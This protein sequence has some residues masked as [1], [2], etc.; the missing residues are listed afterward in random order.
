M[1]VDNSRK[2][3]GTN[4]RMHLCFDGSR[5]KGTCPSSAFQSLKLFVV[6]FILNFILFSK[7]T[8]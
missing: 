1:H 3:T 5:V 7:H 2:E 8:I 6:V 4:E